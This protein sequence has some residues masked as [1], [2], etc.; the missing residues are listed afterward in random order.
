MVR[1][2]ITHVRQQA[3]YSVS[4]LRALRRHVVPTPAAGFEL[5]FT[6]GRVAGVGVAAAVVT[7]LI[8]SDPVAA[9]E[10]PSESDICE[11][12]LMTFIDGGTKAITFIAPVVGF[13]NAGV[14]FTKAAG[15]NKSQ[16][17]KEAKENIRSSIMYGLAGG[18]LSAIVA[19]ILTFGP[20][21]TCDGLF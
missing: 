21:S 9:Q 20:M 18:F 5:G 16:K 1:D 4:T 19:L 15:T 12:D 11:N 13:A 8:A 2:Y 17:K 14:N 6:A 10:G 7:L 3:S